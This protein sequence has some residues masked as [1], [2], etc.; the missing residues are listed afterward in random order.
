MAWGLSLLCGLGHLGHVWPAAPGWVHALHHPVLAATM[1]A[2][3]L[4]GELRCGIEHPSP[5][6]LRLISTLD[7]WQEVHQLPA[8]VCAGDNNRTCMTSA[9]HWMYADIVCGVLLLLQVPVVTSSAVAG[10]HCL[11]GG[12]T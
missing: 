6:L 10:R 12:L 1:S 5:I 2:A 9:H 4:L 11:W 3:A 8:A 7:A